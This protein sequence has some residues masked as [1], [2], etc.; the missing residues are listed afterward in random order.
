[1]TRRD[2]IIIA[3]FVNAAILLALFI[4]AV[5]SKGSEKQPPTPL[6]ES[7]AGSSSDLVLAKTEGGAAKPSLVQ[8]PEIKTAEGDEVDLVLKQFAQSAAQ[9]AIAPQ[10]EATPLAPSANAPAQFSQDLQAFMVTPS[11]ATS[12]VLPPPA[13]T[14]APVATIDVTVRKGDVLEKIARAHRTTVK[15]IMRV[16]GL[17]N[18]NLRIGQV[19]KVTPGTRGGAA[20][21]AKE[22]TAARY[23]TVKNGDNPWTIAVKNHLKVEQLLRLNNMDENK[24]RRLKPGDQLRIE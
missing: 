3:V 11:A 21:P 4:S 13:P 16:N 2:T 18:A 24:A 22:G 19:L 1:M 6:V 20:A 15:E 8:S 12:A 17:K 5:R 23:Y 7:S 14:T 10:T 9:L